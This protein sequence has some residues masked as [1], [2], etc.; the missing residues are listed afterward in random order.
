MPAFTFLDNPTPGQL[1]QITALYHAEGWFSGKRAGDDLA[2]GIIAGSHC[3]VIATAGS[4]IIGMG[5]SISDGISDA[6]VQD[7]TVKNVYRKLGIGSGIIN[8]LIAR[9]EADRLKWIGLVAERESYKFYE[10][11]GFKKMPNSTP[12]LKIIL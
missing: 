10:R 7:V 1:R 3:F 2:A 6:Y 4:E 12:M 5:R 8:A 11:L 9:L